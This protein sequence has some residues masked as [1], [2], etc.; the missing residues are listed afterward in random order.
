MGTTPEA[1]QDGPPLLVRN[2]ASRN[3]VTFEIEF[4]EDEEDL[5]NNNNNMN[6]NNEDDEQQNMH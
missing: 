4:N 2:T 3:K 6:D 5:G 1:A